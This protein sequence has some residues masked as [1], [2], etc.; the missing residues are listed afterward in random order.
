VVEQ[1]IGGGG[2]SASEG[3]TGKGSVEAILEKLTGSGG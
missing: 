2:T 1:V 3:S